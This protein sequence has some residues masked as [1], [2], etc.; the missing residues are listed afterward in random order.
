MA[1]AHRI[2]SVQAEVVRALEQAGAFVFDCSA[3]GRGF[4]DLFVVFRGHVFL[5]ECKTPGGQLTAAEKRFAML[6]PWPVHI[7]RSAD[8]ALKAIGLV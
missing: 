6:C 7:V 8:D 1:F 5:L 3:L 4:P 2:D